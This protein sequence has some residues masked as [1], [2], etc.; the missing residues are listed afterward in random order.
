MKRILKY[1]ALGTALLITLFILYLLLWP[2]KIDP[3]AWTPPEAP[4]LTGLP[5]AFPSLLAEQYC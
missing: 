4:A 1:A 5:P 2:V 3:V